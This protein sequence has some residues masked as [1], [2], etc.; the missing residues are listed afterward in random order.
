M[1]K[2]MF[3]VLALTVVFV[4]AATGAAFA[5]W[6]DGTYGTGYLGNPHGGYTSATNRCGVCHS[7]HGASA[8]GEALLQS[9][10]ANSCTYCHITSGAY[11]TVYNGAAANY[12]VAVNLPNAHNTVTGGT[13]YLQTVGCPDCH[14]VHGNNAVT[15]SDG[16]S[17]A[18]GN[19]R[20]LFT[21][22]RGASFRAQAVNVASGRTGSYATF[23]TAANATLMTQWCSQCHPYYN[24]GVN[25]ASHRMAASDGTH[26]FVKSDD[27]RDCHDSQNFAPAGGTNN[28]PHIA[29][30]ARFLSTA[31]NAGAAKTPAVAT[32]GRVL[33][34]GACLKCHVNGTVTSG[35]G[36]TY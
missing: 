24:T 26:A 3:M 23:F 10:K 19:L 36:I 9:S 1:S 2:K 28:F 20:N 13:A 21:D 29:D 33:V 4:F 34:D 35:V 31:A 6:G 8:G 22:A 7:V 25:G 14:T 32:G 16:K 17:G 15:I 12:S 18:A 5:A 11:T 27:C 30:G